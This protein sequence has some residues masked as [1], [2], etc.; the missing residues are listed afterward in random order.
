[1]MASEIGAELAGVL[2]E[3]AGDYKDVRDLRPYS[4]DILFDYVYKKYKKTTELQN[5][6]PLT[7]TD[8]L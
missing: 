8:F 2:T 3:A 5:P 4:Y 6:M 1:M 7:F